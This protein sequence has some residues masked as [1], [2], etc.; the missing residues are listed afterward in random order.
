MSPATP[1][2]QPETRRTDNIDTY[3]SATRGQVRVPDPYHWLEEYSEETDRWIE[4]QESFTRTYLDKNLGRQ[5]LE[6][7]LQ[8]VND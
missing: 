7:V 5:R 8:E 6:T 1:K 2:P 3:K 4:I